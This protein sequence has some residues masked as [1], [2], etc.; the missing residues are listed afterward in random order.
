MTVPVID[1]HP[2]ALILSQLLL[3]L[4][5]RRESWGLILFS[6]FAACHLHEFKFVKINIPEHASLTG[7][8]L[9]H[10]NGVEVNKYIDAKRA[11]FGDIF[12]IEAAEDGGA[13]F[14]TELLLFVR[15]SGRIHGGGRT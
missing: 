9:R 3:R 12:H 15:E 13:A 8:S 2:I 1:F 14:G 6:E 5:D 11:V 7:V 10:C 4:F